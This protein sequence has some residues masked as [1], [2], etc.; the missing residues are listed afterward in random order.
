MPIKPKT[1]VVC[2]ATYIPRSW[3][4]TMTPM[5]SAACKAKRREARRK[6]VTAP[7]K[8][9]GELVALQGRRGLEQ[10]RTG[11]VYCSD[12]CKRTWISQRARQTLVEINRRTASKRMKERNPMH[13]PETRAK[14]SASLKA[15]GWRP[16]VRGGNGRGLTE[17]QA[18]LSQL[19]DW[20][21]EVVVC[22]KMPRG[23]GYPTNYKLDVGEPD[24]MVGIE[25]DGFSH[26]S[27]R[28]QAQDAKKDGFLS[29]LGWTV[30]RFTNQEVM[31]DLVGCVRTVV[32]TIWKSRSITTTS[33]TAS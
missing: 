21:T 17:P 23:S 20:P 28:R 9:C 19:L 33:P 12:V 24:L 3:N 26:C 25:I 27:R 32:S 5:C 14:V 16:P 10:A 6:K 29:S 1:C 2:G 15:M 13:N 30:L 4:P 8:Q 11:A 18:A 7:C 22:T 31:D